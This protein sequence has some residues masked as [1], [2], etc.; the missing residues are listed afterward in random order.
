M[1]TFSL[2][3][4]RP[5]CITTHMEQ[6]S[7]FI[8]LREGAF[9]Q[10]GRFFCSIPLRWERIS[11]TFSAPC[12]L[13]QYLSENDPYICQDKPQFFASWK[14]TNHNQI[15]TAKISAKIWNACIFPTL[16]MFKTQIAE[17]N[18]RQPFHQFFFFRQK[19]HRYWYYHQASILPAWPVLF[20]AY[21]LQQDNLVHQICF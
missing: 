5:V 21:C 8:F 12:F 11:M 10:V 15:L 9:Q 19:F 17:D 4:D 3:G 18:S 14:R 20:T 6:S 16:Y 7:F 13:L 1:K 2:R